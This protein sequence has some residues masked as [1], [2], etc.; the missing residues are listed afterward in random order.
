MID[1]ISGEYQI[2]VHADGTA[3]AR[4][5]DRD[6]A[7]YAPIPPIVKH[8]GVTYPVTSLRNCFCGCSSLVEAPEIPE[9]VTDMDRCF[10]GCSSLAE[11]PEIPKGVTNA[12]SCF[13]GCHSLA[14]TPN[15]PGCTEPCQCNIGEETRCDGGDV[16][17]TLD[18]CD[19][20]HVF[21]TMNHNFFSNLSRFV[22]RVVLQ[23]YE[24]PGGVVRVPDCVE[25]IGQEAFAYCNHVT[26]VILPVADPAPRRRLLRGT[27]G[28]RGW[29]FHREEG[30]PPCSRRH[31]CRLAR[32]IN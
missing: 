31:D 20:G 12:A 26:D 9:G 21:H 24:G 8:E 2:T 18:L 27:P 17:H 4:V 6:Q 28:D 32:P 3:S 29:L 30:T 13:H 15:L 22:G 16:F 1:F 5:I 7:R 14:D 19:G 10:C 11:A 23:S 25:E